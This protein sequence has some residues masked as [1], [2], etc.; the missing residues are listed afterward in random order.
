[1]AGGLAAGLVVGLLGAAGAG[2]ADYLAQVPAADSGALVSV[3]LIVPFTVFYGIALVL[4]VIARRRLQDAISDPSLTKLRSARSS[5]L[6]SQIVI[7]VGLVPNGYLVLFS[8]LGAM[9]LRSGGGFIGLLAGWAAQVPPIVG[10]ITEIVQLV[11]SRRATRVLI[12]DDRRWWWDGSEWKSLDSAADVMASASE[13]PV[14][15]QTLS[16]RARKATRRS[17]IAIGAGAVLALIAASAGAVGGQQVDAQRGVP[18]RELELGLVFLVPSL[19]VAA[20]ALLL[21]LISL[22]RLGREKAGEE[23]NA[24]LKSRPWLKASRVVLWCSLAVTLY[25]ALGVA[26]TPLMVSTQG[27]LLANV[28]ADVAQWLLLAAEIVALVSVFRA[29]RVAALPISGDG[30]SWW[31][32]VTWQPFVETGAAAPVR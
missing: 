11:R 26:F 27:E 25:L 24:L 13:A 1:M 8:A 16:S 29:V 32:G 5:L 28:V 7:A 17:V 4:L 21:L 10:A 9:G 23:R 19:L 3:A 31:N 14:S 20:A 18:N 30:R 15:L 12:S 2:F 22:V 6:A